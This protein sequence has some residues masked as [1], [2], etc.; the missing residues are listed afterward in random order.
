MRASVAES[1]GPIHLGFD[2]SKNKFAIAT[3]RRGEQVPDV[4]TIINDEASVRRLIGRF[5]NRGQLRVCYEAGP[6]GFGLYRLLTSMGVACD[7]VAPAPSGSTPADRVKTDRR[8]CRRLARLHR[9][10]ELVAIRV[11]SEAE[12]AVRDLCRARAD[13]VA[14]RTRTRHRLAKFLLRHDR[15]WRQDA[16]TAKHEQWL[17]GQ[18]FDNPALRSTYAHYRAMVAARD[19]ELDALEADLAHWYTHGPFAHAVA[20][21]AAY[22]G[23]AHLG[24]L[25]IA[26]EV[27]RARP[28]GVLL[29]RVCPPWTH[30]QGRQR[31]PPHAA[32]RIRVGL[33]TPG[34]PRHRVAS[35]PRRRRPGHRGAILDRP[36]APVRPVP[37]AQLPQD[38]PQHRRRGHRPRTRRVLLGRNDRHPKLKDFLRCTRVRITH[39]SEP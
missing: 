16:W 12:E 26:S 36:S 14:D 11:P 37:P 35:P 31:P 6:T 3:L 34:Q 8:D 30:H 27:H 28:L 19:A 15:V 25:T 33:P 29:R 20:R 1:A 4:E 7:V 23:V 18:R 5:P 10:G 2:M 32:D 38:Q 13:L 17:A 9:A 24:A 39:R 21:L 22:R